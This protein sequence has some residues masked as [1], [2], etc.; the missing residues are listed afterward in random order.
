MCVLVILGTWGFLQCEF[1]ELTFLDP[2]RGSLGFGEEAL[3]SL[4][5]NVGRQ[6]CFCEFIF[7]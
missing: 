6:V 7:L 3:Q 4:P 1:L 5:G 2:Y